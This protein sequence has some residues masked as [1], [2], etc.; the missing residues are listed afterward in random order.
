MKRDKDNTNI[1]HKLAKM[2]TYVNS[3][4][5]TSNMNQNT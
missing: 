4:K 5:V 1:F 3:R 2:G